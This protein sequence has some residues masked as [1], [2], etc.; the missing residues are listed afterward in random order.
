MTLSLSGLTRWSRHLARGFTLI[1]LLVV[2]AI[3]AILIGLLLPAVQKVREAAARSKC[4]N[5]LKQFGLALH[6]YHD[7][8]G[9]FPQGGFYLKDTAGN[10]DWANGEGPSW[11]TLTMPQM[12]QEPSFRVMS[13]M[14]GGFKT[15]NVGY[16]WQV[17]D[18]PPIGPLPTLLR[19]G[20]K[21]SANY[22]CPSDGE[23]TNE[24]LSNYS[25][26]IG[27][28]PLPSHGGS[29]EPFAIHEFPQNNSLGDWGY[30]NEPNRW[31]GHGNT[32]DTRWT[33][34]FG[35]RLGAKIN[36]AGIT[37]G[38]SNTIAIGEILPAWHDHHGNGSWMRANGGVC[39]AATIVPINF[40]IDI[41][42]TLG[43]TDLKRQPPNNWAVSW[44][45]K[46]RHTG[47][48]NFLFGDGTVRFVNQNIDM[49][50]YNLL[51]ARSDGLPVNSP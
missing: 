48:A 30:R 31:T 39:H 15:R 43:S 42:G 35:T 6:N 1:E 41:N 25:M 46:S 21:G 49:R 34:G 12:E 26:S 20:Y 18:P 51:G 2:I 24:T 27:P 13:D 44:G 40:P 16:E 7:V 4:Q 45:F 37:D 28:M 8:N 47:G 23:R 14:T 36:I 50:T 9:F 22:R 19:N 3:I 32:E 11:M 38:T 10:I 33:L 17:N 5:N 29:P